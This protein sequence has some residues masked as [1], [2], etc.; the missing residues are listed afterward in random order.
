MTRLVYNRI[1][2][3]GSSA[4][5][6]LLLKL[7][8]LNNFTL[9]RDNDFYPNSTTLM[10]HLIAMP[11]N[12][13]YIN[14]CNYIEG[15]PSD[16][17]WINMA[18]EPVEREVSHYYYTVDPNLRGKKAEASVELQKADPCGCAY[19]EFD[20][21]IKF[22]YESTKP[23]C[24]HALDYISLSQ[25]GF[26][27]SISPKAEIEESREPIIDIF[28]RIKNKYLFVGLTDEFE[29]SV[30]MFEKL[31]PQFFAGAVTVYAD[32]PHSRATSDEN[33]LTKTKLTGAISN[34]ARKILE[35]HNA[36]ETLLYENI[37]R[38]FWL[39]IAE[40]HPQLLSLD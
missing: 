6:Y 40:H 19:M 21:C 13:A 17:V 34:R 28:N 20:T 16:Y 9:Y 33:P 18:R 7:S 29:L 35:S 30:R 37:K 22:R 4:M 12:S 2:K 23:N 39:R 36:E 15:L 5:T 24:T 38:L 10:H 3:A 31:L 32:Y 25:M 1:S 8:I 27:R 14:H 11:E 26:F